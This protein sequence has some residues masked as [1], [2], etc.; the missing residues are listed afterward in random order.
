MKLFLHKIRHWEYWSIYLIYTP[1]FF[2]WVYY[3]IKFRSIAFF[4]YVNPAI[5][6]GGFFG[7]SK[8]AIYKILPKNSYP[9]TVFIAAKQDVDFPRIL[10]ENELKFPLIVKPDIGYRGIGLAKVNSVQELATYHKE[11]NFD[12]LIQETI[13]FP[14]EIGLFYC[15]IPNSNSGFISGVTIKR[16]VEIVG[17]GK[18]TIEKLVNKT[19][20][21]AFQLQKISQSC[22]LN[23]I[24]PEG[25]T[26]RL[27]PFGNHSRGTTFLDGQHLLT[28]DLR[29]TF[30]ALLSPIDG[31]YYGRLDI[32]YAS[33][34]E[35]EQGKAFS[36][37]E[38]N[39]VKSEPTHM[40]DP[41]Y[42]FWHAQIEIFRHQ[43]II[44]KIAGL[45]LQNARTK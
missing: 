33:F 2:L 36:I 23:E 1:A 4:R 24:L 3:M 29:K 13:E 44:G 11:H 15:K 35:L 18:D 27:V 10:I 37:I 31:F 5:K 6:N 34:E 7:D 20:R 28:K 16:F 41:K 14:N 45:V 26:K 12:F 38:L 21:F 40:Y 30:D 17:N 25:T 9:K 43:K 39:G 19:P 22:D 8:Y 42:S 32:R